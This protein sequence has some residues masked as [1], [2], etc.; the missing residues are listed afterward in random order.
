MKNVTIKVIIFIFGLSQAGVALAGDAESINKRQAS[1]K[2]RIKKGIESGELNKKEAARMKKG[3]KRVRKMER[4]AK[5]DGE[6]SS[7][8]AARIQK[9]QNKQSRKIRKQKH[10]GQKRK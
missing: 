10:D 2:A 6:I 9:V 4:R 7:A 1:Q 8:E 5:K 3:Q